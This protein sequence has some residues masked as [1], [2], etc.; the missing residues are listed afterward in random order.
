[1]ASLRNPCLVSLCGWKC[2][3]LE[4]VIANPPQPAQPR[5]ERSR[6]PP[7]RQLQDALRKDAFGI[8]PHLPE[9]FAIL[10]AHR[11][12]WLSGRLSSTEHIVGCHRQH[13]G[14]AREPLPGF[15]SVAALEPAQPDVGDARAVGELA[16]CE[17]PRFAKGAQSRGGFRHLVLPVD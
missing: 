17:P 7:T 4:S 16:L 1:M 3:A 6:P 15:R 11:I 9:Q 12:D 13:I 5:A 10:S 8:L 14:E 2:G